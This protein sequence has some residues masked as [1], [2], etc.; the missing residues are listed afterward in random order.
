MSRSVPQ[1]VW[2]STPTLTLEKPLPLGR[3]R[4]FSR[5]IVFANMDP[6]VP[7]AD[8]AGQSSTLLRS[9]QQQMEVALWNEYLMRAEGV[10]VSVQTIT[11]AADIY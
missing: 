11:G 3:V 4:V 10:E 1:G 7:P 6:H 2:T 8:H 9:T 5:V